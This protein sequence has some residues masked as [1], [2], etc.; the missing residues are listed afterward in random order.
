M[1]N[2]LTA[3]QAA[4][5]LGVSQSTVSRYMRSGMLPTIRIGRKVRFPKETVER[6][7]RELDQGF[8]V[9]DMKGEVA[10]LK[11]EV[12]RLKRLVDFLMLKLGLR[13][14]RWYLS[15]S[16]LMSVYEM[17]SEV[18][19]QVSRKHAGE[20]LEVILYLTEVEFERLTA[21]TGDPYPWRRAFTYTEGLVMKLHNKKNYRSNIELQALTQNL[22]M[23]QQ[24]I[25][26]CALLLLTTTPD[27]MPATDR[28]DILLTGRKTEE[29]DP[30]EMLKRLK[31]P[32][33]ATDSDRKKLNR[34]LREL[35]AYRGD[36]PEDEQ[37]N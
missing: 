3:R 2:L 11:Y 34:L 18:P 31:A 28:F 21:L 9:K 19:R 20:W 17:C 23:A 1:E 25:R 13:D 37:E 24:E 7:R 30:D 14:G 15:D 35:T 6:F 8:T 33:L 16:D 27:R 29:A 36:P 10:G 32:N 5:V 22:V 12:E 26:K 4:R